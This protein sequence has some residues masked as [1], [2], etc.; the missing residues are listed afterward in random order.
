MILWGDAGWRCM[1]GIPCFLGYTSA[2][3]PNDGSGQSL[4]MTEIWR[5]KIEK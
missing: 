5:A 4:I 2:M 3:H 1:S